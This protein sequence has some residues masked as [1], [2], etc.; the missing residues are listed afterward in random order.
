M[1]TL[2]RGLLVGVNAHLFFAFSNLDEMIA[3]GHYKLSDSEVVEPSGLI[4]G[5]QLFVG[6]RADKETAEG[7]CRGVAG[8]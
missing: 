3:D 8:Q 5:N 2:H 1:R 4:N 6:L 7:M